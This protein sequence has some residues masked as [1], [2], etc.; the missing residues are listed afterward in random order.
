MK[1]RSIQTK[2]VLPV[3]VVGVV[4]VVVCVGWMFRMKNRNVETS[5]L[6]SAKDIS[7]QVVTLRKVYTTEIVSRAKKAGM[8]VNYDF[9]NKEKTL[10]LPATMVK[11]LGDQITSEHPGT[12]IRLYSRYPFPNR[13]DTE[14]YDQFE[15]DA[16]GS[17]EKDPKT[18]FYRLETVN[19]RLS[20]RYAVADV[21][22]Q[23]CVAC[24]NSHPE[25]PKK[26]WKVGDVR[27]VV[28]T[29][30]PVDTMEA[31]FRASTWKLACMVALG[32]FSIAIIILFLL[33]QRV[34][35]PIRALSEV[36]YR[37]QHEGDISVGV[38]FEQQNDEIGALGHEVNGMGDYLR[39]MADIADNIAKG[40][41]CAEV[42]PLSNKD[43]FGH[44]FRNMLNYLRDAVGNIKSGSNGMAATSTELTNAGENSEQA[45][46][47]LTS[48]TRE[49]AT[50]IQQ[51]T[52]SISKVSENAQFQSKNVTEV[53][54]A[55]S[56]MVASLQHIANNTR[57]LTTLTQ[58][59]NETAQ[60][61]QEV[62]KQDSERMQRISHSVAQVGKTIHVLGSRVQDI[63]KIV[64]TIDEIADQTNL[65]AL[66][67]A[68][69]AARAGENGLGFA[70]VA[71]EVRKLAERSAHSTSE[72]SQ[73]IE[74]IQRESNVAVN[75]M[76]DAHKTVEEYI[77]NTSISDSLSSIISTIEQVVVSTQEIEAATNEQSVGA[78]QIDQAMHSLS[79]LTLEISSSANEQSAGVSEAINA[80]DRL[81]KVVDQVA[82]MTQMLQQS[83]SQL[84]SQAFVLQQVTNHFKVEASSDASNITVYK[85]AA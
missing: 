74:A 82:S 7:D 50:V 42:K 76:N 2:L 78:E 14:R 21:M 45:A 20:M 51:I 79:Q 70:V 26:D 25:S 72:I 65:L 53:S 33:R 4:I 22:G 32:F 12:V 66:N 62:L 80:M 71:D 47:E 64:Q 68:I 24:H 44:A 31:E 49:I 63:G 52:D 61:G 43:K 35:K 17:L 28:E 23:T 84:Q 18:P 56:Q 36:S 41:L 5:G 69:E 39:G 59:A 40:D 15:Q 13:K 27:G 81:H 67:A 34:V 57:Q 77:S 8:E 48:S 16:I 10:P 85:Q 30:V 54:A 3:I 60:Q 6:N 37:I 58:S 83:A 11:Y 19:G 75:Q 55:I 46:K 9:L 29:V 73:L 1:E 38:E